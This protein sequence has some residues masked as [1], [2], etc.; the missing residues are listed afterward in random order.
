M[1]LSEFFY[2]LRLKWRVFLLP[3]TR[4][5]PC[6]GTVTTKP[7]RRLPGGGMQFGGSWCDACDSNYKPHW[8]DEQFR[9]YWERDPF[10]KRTEQSTQVRGSD[11]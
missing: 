8:T 5:C 4:P 11:G 1:T 9:Y 6:G 10:R 2:W 3:K 7:D